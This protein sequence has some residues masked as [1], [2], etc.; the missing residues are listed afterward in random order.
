MD[1]SSF[2][3]RSLIGLSNSKVE[4]FNRSF[5]EVVLD[6]Y[7]IYSLEDVQQTFDACRD[8]Y[9]RSYPHQALGG[10]PPILYEVV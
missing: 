3:T 7:L 6:T 5:R 8:D 1:L 4:R 9:N 10:I 2:A